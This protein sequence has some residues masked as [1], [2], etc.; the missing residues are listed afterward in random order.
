M[1]LL[2][3]VPLETA[4]EER[5]VATVPD[6]VEK[7]IKLGFSVAVQSGAGTGANFSDDD[8]RTAGAE[9]VATA[10][11]LWGRSDIV[12]KV[13]PPSSEEVALLREGSTLVGFVWPAQN[14]E[15]MQQLAAKRATVLAIDSLPRTLSRAQKMDALT[16]MAGVSGYRA[17]IEAAHAFGRY[18]NGQ[19]TA[20]GKVP[21]AKVFVAGAGVAGLA[22]I[23]TAAGL[24]AIVRANDTRAEVAD[25][26]K[27][28]GG[29][30]VKVDY[31]EEGSGGGGYAKVMSEGFQQAQRAMYAQQAK[32]ADII[33]TTAL[34]P[35]KPAPKL[36]T[37]EMVQ[38]MKP[39]SV[40]V[41]MAG[42]QGGNCELTVPGEAVVRHG[43]TIVGYT[44]LASRLARQS[45]TLYATNLL[46]VIE[47]LCKAK[48]G[49]INVDFNDDAIRGL[50]V[51]KE[52]NVTWPPPPIQQPAAV[53]KP[54]A[55]PVAATASKGHGHGSGEPMSA[56]SLAIVFAVGALAFLLVGQFAPATF[57]AHF[58]VFVLACFVGY[59]VIWNVTPSLHTPLM[60]VTN[61]ISSIIAIGALVQVAPPLGEAAAGDRPSGLILGLAVGAL[62]LTAVNMFGGF[63][64]TRRMLAMFRK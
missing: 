46:R 49:T 60:S 59:M 9:V 26:V 39:G 24:G 34:I 63:A 27:S 42:E 56:K 30:F 12:L 15:L 64:V 18:F 37:A 28:L 32:D 36:I 52:G 53:P 11:D 8:Y 54:A 2:I 20:A 58:T 57:L 21:P 41:D 31:E 55:A 51:I 16:S 33:I 14:P 23:G 7:L 4:N 29:E 61:A 10:A 45:S 25:Q 38:S 50:T 40:I 6:V 43:V 1:T 62:T 17:V 13:R 35:G 44:D 19:I 48:D 3:G 47:E 5:R 22:A